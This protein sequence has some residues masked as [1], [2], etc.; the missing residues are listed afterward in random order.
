MP[1]I[2]RIAS[3]LTAMFI[4]TA[5]LTALPGCPASEGEGEGE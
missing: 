1:R 3:I 2:I 5:A 4:A